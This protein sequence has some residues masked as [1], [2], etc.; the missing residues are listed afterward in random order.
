MLAKTPEP[1]YY[2]VILASERTE[3]T[4]QRSAYEIMASQML[5]MAARQPGCLG[6]T[7]TYN[8]QTYVNII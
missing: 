2:S 5:D 3:V 7:R 4:P 6:Y 8:N 1:P